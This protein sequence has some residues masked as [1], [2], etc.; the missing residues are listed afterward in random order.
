[1]PLVFRLFTLQ[2]QMHT[3]RYVKLK[4]YIHIYTI[5]YNY[6]WQPRENFELIEHSTHTHGTLIYGSI[7]NISFNLVFFMEPYLVSL[8]MCV[9][10]CTLRQKQLNQMCLKKKKVKR[11]V[12]KGKGKFHRKKICFLTQITIQNNAQSDCYTQLLRTISNSFMDYYRS[13]VNRMN[14]IECFRKITK[15]SALS[16]QIKIYIVTQY[17]IHKLYLSILLCIP[18]FIL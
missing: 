14:F 8:Y 9:C 3:Y 7:L 12:A 17:G 2:M 6:I 13:Q 10:V 18:Q 1:M 15:I 4:K 16:K 5:N 11:N